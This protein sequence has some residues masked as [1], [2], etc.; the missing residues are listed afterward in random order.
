WLIP[1]IFVFYKNHLVK[2]YL[3]W[4]KTNKSIIIVFFV[5]GVFTL[6][7]TSVLRTYLYQAYHFHKGIAWKEIEEDSVDFGGEPSVFTLTDEF[8]QLTLLFSG[9]WV[10][11]EGVMATVVYPYSSFKFFKTALAN[12]PSGNDVGIY[13]TEVLGPTTDHA[14]N[15]MFA[16]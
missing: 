5:L 13:T 10:G 6:S 12:K 14:Y 9:R 16:S 1:Y 8:S 7:A 15:N 2:D 4:I 11:L 3:S